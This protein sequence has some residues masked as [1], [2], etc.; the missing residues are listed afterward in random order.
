MSNNSELI[1]EPGALDE[2]TRLREFIRPNNPKAAANAA[3]CI[4]DATNLLLDHPHLGH[5]IADLPEFNELFIAF[6][7]YGY[8]IR[9]RII[10]EKIVILRVWHT[11]EDR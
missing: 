10:N 6:G 1:W 2:L 11:R 9:Y 7:Q 8:V 5:P 4:I 3:R